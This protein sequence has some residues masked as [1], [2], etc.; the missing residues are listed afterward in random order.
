[1]DLVQEEAE[2]LDAYSRFVMS[3]AEKLGPSVANL[4]VMLRRG[5]LLPST[6]RLVASRP[7]TETL[8]PGF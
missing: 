8:L 6:D 5:F 2:A 1:M 7:M 3:V 4:R